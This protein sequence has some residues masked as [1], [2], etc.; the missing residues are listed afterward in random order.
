[1]AGKARERGERGGGVKDAVVAVV[2]KVKK[3]VGTSR[4]E[5]GG[6]LGVSEIRREGE[7]RERGVERR[8]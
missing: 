2:V 4:V 8:G 1:M 7:E 5:V 6:L 3:A